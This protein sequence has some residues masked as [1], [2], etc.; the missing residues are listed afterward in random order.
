MTARPIGVI[1]MTDEKGKD[2]KIIAVSHFDAEY[3]EVDD[4]SRL[5]AHR[6]RELERFFLDYKTLE[7]KEV[8]IDNLHG[9][10]EAGR[11]ILEAVKLYDTKIAP[12]RALT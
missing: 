1:T 6:L 8:N 5:S 2:D 4:I 11:V 9:R 12:G 3:A 10:D 7:N